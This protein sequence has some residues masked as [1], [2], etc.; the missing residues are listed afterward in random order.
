MRIVV[1]PR[2][3]TALGGARALSSMPVA[4]TRY[5]LNGTEAVS[6]FGESL[7]LTR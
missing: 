1:D 4:S 3:V 7:S 5:F 6:T 2:L